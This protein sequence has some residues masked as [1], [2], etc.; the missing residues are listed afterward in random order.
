MEKATWFL[1]CVVVVLSIAS[2]AVYPREEAGAKSQLTGQ[3]ESATAPA[4][5][6]EAE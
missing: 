2:A 1:V 3:V 5:D 4:S 6:T